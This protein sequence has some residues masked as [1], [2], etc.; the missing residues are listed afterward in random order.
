M[1]REMENWTLSTDTLER[2]IATLRHAST[3]EMALELGALWSLCDEA[4]DIIEGLMHYEQSH[5]LRT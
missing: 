4:A 2:A 3:G 5:G 1:E